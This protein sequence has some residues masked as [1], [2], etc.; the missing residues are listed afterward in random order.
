MLKIKRVY[1]DISQQDGKRI[2][3]DGMWPRGI[4]KAD[5][6]HDEWLKDLAPSR[7]LRKWFNHDADKWSDFKKKY[8]KELDDHREEL[9]NIKADSEGH[10]VTLL[11]AAKDEH[12]NQ[13][14]AMKEYIDHM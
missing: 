3:V 13:A 4:K 2:L 9:E 10:N 14:V 12:Y 5:L 1:D 6:K 11:Y 8:F 7:E